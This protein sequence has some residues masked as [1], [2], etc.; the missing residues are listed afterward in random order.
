MEGKKKTKVILSAPSS[1]IKS[2]GGLQ[3]TFISSTSNSWRM[4]VAGDFG[5]IQG[6]T[7]S[8]FWLSSGNDG[9][10]S[11][12]DVPAAFLQEPLGGNPFIS[13]DLP[14]SWGLILCIQVPLLKKCPVI[15][16]FLS[17][18]WLMYHTEN[19]FLFRLIITRNYELSLLYKLLN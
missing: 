5:S 8:G 17:V 15:Y 16:I 6:T 12:S 13:L 18:H 7:R 2:S 4:Q 11:S 1:N 3:A 14:V 19:C 9:S 10:K